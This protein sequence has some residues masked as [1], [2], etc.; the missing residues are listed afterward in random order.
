MNKEI[1]MQ[2]LKKVLR[3]GKNLAKKADKL[4]RETGIK[5]GRTQEPIRS[6]IKRLIKSGL[7]IGSLP[8]Y[9]YWIIKNNKELEEVIE[10][11]KNRNKGVN[12]RIK[13]IREAFGNFYNQK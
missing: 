13:E 12:N 2:K 10:N 7:P 3:K 8:K 9:G 1:D 11:L 5:S 4:Q 6:L